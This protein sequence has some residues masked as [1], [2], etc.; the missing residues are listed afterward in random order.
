MAQRLARHKIPLTPTPC[1]LGPIL[2]PSGPKQSTLALPHTVGFHGPMSPPSSVSPPSSQRETSKALAQAQPQPQPRPQAQPEMDVKKWLVWDVVPHNQ[3]D[4]GSPILLGRI[5]PDPLMG[6]TLP[7]LC[8]Q[9]KGWAKSGLCRVG[10]PSRPPWQTTVLPLIFSR[11]CPQPAPVISISS[12]LVK[13][14]GSPRGRWGGGRYGR[15]G[16]VPEGSNKEW[17][18]H[19]VWAGTAFQTDPLTQKTLNAK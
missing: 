1:D 3:A 8:Q 9:P 5:S 2:A 4:C 19:M 12:P 16:V 14:E 7:P 15:R 18:P 10:F 17:D 6:P 13:D 11:C